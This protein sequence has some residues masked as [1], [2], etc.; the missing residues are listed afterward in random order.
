MC[1]EY[2]SSL[3]I[4]QLSCFVTL[5]LP[6]QKAHA[7]LLSVVAVALCHRRSC[8]PSIISKNFQYRIYS[9]FLFKTRMHSD[10]MLWNG[11]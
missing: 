9:L 4:F 11:P 2:Q 8:C 10:P 1:L 7:S 5:R 6:E 3:I